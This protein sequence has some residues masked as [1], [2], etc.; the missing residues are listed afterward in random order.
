MIRTPTFW[1][2]EKD[3]PLLT[4][5]KGYLEAQGDDIFTRVAS[6]PGK[7]GLDTSSSSIKLIHVD[8]PDRILIADAERTF[9][10]QQHR[11]DFVKLT[12]HLHSSFNDYAQGLG[13]VSSFL[14]LTMNTTDEINLLTL[15]NSSPKY[16][17]GYWKHE[18]I[19]FATDAF[20]FLDLL[21][22][23]HP[24]IAAHFQK[25]TIDPGTFCQ[26][27]FVGLC[28]HVLP[29][30]YL[31][32]YYE[33]FLEDG[34]VFLMKFGLS[35]VS[36]LRDSILKINN[37]PSHIFGLL[38][39]DPKFIPHNDSFKIF[40]DKVFN[41]V[42]NYNL[43]EINWE[44]MRQQAYDNNLKKRMESAKKALEEVHDDEIEDCQICKDDFPEVLCK[45]CNLKI[46]ENC[47]KKPPAD[48]THKSTHKVKP[49]DESGDEDE[50]EE[51]EEE[52]EPKKP[53]PKKEEPKKEELKKKDEEIDE[54][55]LLSTRIGKL[56]V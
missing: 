5:N 7:A 25:N 33:R 28:V 34:F 13:Y 29:F 15:L 54:V 1:Q 22:I 41:D 48:S 39:L 36:N 20:V 44:T 55:E 50:E 56:T 26:K 16:V 12:A 49:V 42:K 38:R 43:S 52:E 40:L 18:A 35:L 4:L 19:K 24:E 2:T 45:Q 11:D 14:S 21:K 17:P 47:H 27:W 37:N 51:D 8:K 6:W 32:T 31:F 46:C 23:Y 3:A 53:E 9:K 30:E 10:S